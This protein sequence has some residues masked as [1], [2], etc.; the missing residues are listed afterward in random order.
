[1]TIAQTLRVLRRGG[2]NSSRSLF[3]PRSHFV[4]RATRSCPVPSCSER[5][6]ADNVLLAN[7]AGVVQGRGR[8]GSCMAQLLKPRI[9]RLCPSRC[10]LLSS[11]SEVR[12]K[13]ELRK[14]DHFSDKRPLMPSTP[15]MYRCDTM[16][17]NQ[18]LALF[19]ASQ[20]LHRFMHESHSTVSL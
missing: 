11:V 8:R 6:V 7:A 20:D 10:I 1:M 19:S 15:L 5:H 12:W 18:R 16:R 2:E 9:V 14:S 17:T 3:Q 13:I 4:A